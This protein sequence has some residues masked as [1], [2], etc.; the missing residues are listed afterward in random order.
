LLRP[1]RESLA[2][3]Q[4]RRHDL[5]GSCRYQSRSSRPTSR[6]L[7]SANES[8]NGPP[9]PFNS[10]VERRQPPLAIASS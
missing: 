6:T 4:R 5:L 7:S 1:V 2:A 9:G 8:H 10:R 3:S